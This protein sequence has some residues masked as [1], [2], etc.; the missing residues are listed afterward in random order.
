MSRR[1]RRIRT[2]GFR[3][4]R[5]TRSPSTERPIVPSSS[6]IL[7]YSDTRHGR[8]LRHG[9][10]DGEDD[11]PGTCG[12][13][14]IRELS[15]RHV[16]GLEWHGSPDARGIIAA[17]RVAV[18]LLACFA[19]ALAPNHLGAAPAA[20]GFGVKIFDSNATLD[21]RDLIGKS[22]LVVRFQASYCKPC[23]RE[24]TAL[25]RLVGR[26]HSRG[27]EFIAFHVQDTVA[28][29]RRFIRSHRVTYPVALDPKLIIGNR[30]GFRGTPYTVVVDRKGEMVAQ[31]H[32]VSAL[33]RLPKILD[34]LVREP[35]PS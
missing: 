24:A 6:E 14:A 29:T 3:P 27:V 11:F 8:R 16:G 19:L 21:S 34:E 4:R 12:S 33:N 22:V 1:R 31:I 2:R 20:P 15:G 35:R 30:F 10:Q 32:G 9:G 18:L 23:G 28:D 26:V 13:S 7:L 5:A 25:S 17:V